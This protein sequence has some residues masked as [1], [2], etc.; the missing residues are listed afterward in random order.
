MCEEL[1]IV[2]PVYNSEG[3]FPELYSRLT[4]ALEAVVHSFEIIAVVDGCRDK[5]FN[6]I[7]ALSEKDARVKAIEFSRNFG[8]Q[9]AITAGL[10]VASGELVAVMDDDL[11]DPPEVLAQFILKLREGYDVVYGIRM[12]R[13]RSLLY[14][15]LYSAFYRTLGKLVELRIPG[16]A[17]DFCVMRRCIVDVLN[18]MPERNRYLRGL[19]AWVGFNQIGMEYDRG[20]RF[21]SKSGY[22]LIKYFSLAI[23]AIFSFSYKPLM[24]VSFIGFFL[25]LVSFVYGAY[26]VIVGKNPVAPGWASLFVAILFLSGIQLL[27]LGIMGQYLARMYDEIK[28]RPQFIV[29][30]TTGLKKEV[31]T[32]ESEVRSQESACP[33]ARLPEEPPCGQGDD[34]GRPGR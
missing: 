21:A 11:E 15:F 9:V 14:R 23:D 25:A 32:K 19:R 31:T 22:N 29:K 30:R 17:G 12:R 5:S 6:V 20:E 7:Q 16:D 3:I 1:S 34:S 33:P 27:S 28:S 13:K 26:V 18:T 4:K 2:I 8:H 10:S 24:Y